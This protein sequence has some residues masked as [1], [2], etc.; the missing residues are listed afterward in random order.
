MKKITLL[1]FSALA[2]TL[3]WNVNAQF[4]EGFETEI[5]ATW[6]VINNGSTNGWVHNAAPSG[7]A[8]EGSAVASILYD[9]SIAHDDYLIT[10]QIA[11]STGVN[12]R[13]SYY[14]KSRSSSFL[15]PYEVLLSTTD[16]MA[17]SFTVTL[18]ASSEAPSTWQQDTFDLSAYNGQSVYVAIRATGTN[19]WELF[20]DNV[21]NDTPPA[22]EV[23]NSLDAVPT[24]VSA[25]V[26]WSAP[27]TGSPTGY[28]WEVQPDGVAQGTA[29]APASGST[30][31]P[32]TSDTATGLTASTAY[33]LYVQTDCGGSGTSTWAGPYSFTT[34]ATPPA[35]DECASAVSLTVE[36]D[37][38]CSSP[39]VGTTIGATESLPGCLGTANDDVWYSFTA[40]ET[41]H[42]II[43]NNT[44]GSSDIVTE[45]FDACGGT[46]IVCQDTPN[47]P[48]EL[49]GL[50]PTSV[51][52]FR[53]YT[54]SSS[55]STTSD[56]EVCVG[57]PSTETLEYYNLQWPAS[58]TI[59]DGDGFNVY[60]QCYE[61]GLTDVTSG[62]APGIECW[63]G[64]STSDTDPSGTGWT[65]VAAA[66]DSEQ[67]NNDQ[68]ILD[69]DA[70]VGVGTYYYAARWSQDLGPYTYGGI[71]AD[72]SYGGI[73]GDDN[74]ISGVLT[75]NPP[76]P[77]ANDDCAN[78]TAIT[79]FS[80]GDTQDASAATNN[81]GFIS[82]CTLSGMNDGVWYTFEV[83]DAGTIVV[84][85]TGLTGWDPEVNVYSGSCGTFTCVGDSD[86][87]CGGADEQITFAATANTQYWVNIGYWS[88]TTD[89]SEGPLT[90]DIST[91]DTATLNPTLS[92]EENQF[93]D[94]KYFPNPVSH[95]L[96]LSAQQNIQNVA[97][98]NIMGQEVMNS[99]PNT[100]SSEIDMS[101]LSRGT[102]FVRVSI[103][104]AIENFK[105]IKE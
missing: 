51:Y 50:T 94:F 91:T 5:P 47:S 98:Y 46:Q 77:P 24:D 36:A 104:G 99:S 64:Y 52:Y 41:V 83:I 27:A 28:N 44:G 68:Y 21:V 78:A 56:F 74:N 25:T 14:I 63:I 42:N 31:A 49:S 26:S 8:Q 80:N 32:T 35:N 53:I 95:A 66:F 34:L 30:T 11:V 70:S 10:P 59:T 2:F 3:S 17:A 43:V 58:G 89:G 102:Y 48:I 100:M 93:A 7:G 82:S 4:T 45:V 76:P 23:P 29:G 54:Y 19:E 38:N 103:N 12:D 37:L 85:V 73:W 57:T 20:V 6:T 105:I 90:I 75:V 84:D 96:T 39:V 65:W 22:C 33:D 92:I 9:S 62:Q 16:A 61:A 71:Q 81:S 55:T 67:G 97:V 87:C 13:L 60:A 40:S 69:L 1:F 88:G 79:A 18:Q 101:A 15:E 72:G 86:A